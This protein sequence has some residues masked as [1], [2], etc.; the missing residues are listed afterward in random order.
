MKPNTEG[1]ETPTDRAI[2][3]GLS[4]ASARTGL[5]RAMLIAKP[6]QLSCII[7]RV[8]CHPSYSALGTATPACLQHQ[9]QHLRLLVASTEE[10][11]T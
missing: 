4:R 3:A 7:L 11:P 5:E 6:A 10:V 8:E 9:R 1:A 2:P